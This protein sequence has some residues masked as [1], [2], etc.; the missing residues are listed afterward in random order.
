[1]TSMLLAHSLSNCDEAN[2]ERTAWKGPKFK[3]K[4]I[5]Y[6]M[7]KAVDRGMC[8]E[9]VRL[10]EKQGGGNRGI[11]SPPPRGRQ[12]AISPPARALALRK[13]KILY[14]PINIFVAFVIRIYRNSGLVYD[15]LKKF[16]L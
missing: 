10:L 12:T 6:D 11:G 15:T 16:N 14:S 8:L 1:M 5:V 3:G 7:C 9:D 4:D 13:I 2:A